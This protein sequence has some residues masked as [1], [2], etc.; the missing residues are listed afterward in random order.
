MHSGIDC[1][2]AINTFVHR[3]CGLAALRVDKKP[4]GFAAAG[5]Q[6]KDARNPGPGVL[7]VVIASARNSIANNAT[8]PRISPSTE[9]D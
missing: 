7:Y 3:V 1:Q 5:D 6:R 4:C 2:V 8:P 9:V